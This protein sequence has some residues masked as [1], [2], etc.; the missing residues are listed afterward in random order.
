MSYLPKWQWL[1]KWTHQ[2]I[3]KDFD[4]TI[5]G[6][7][8]KGEPTTFTHPGERGCVEFEEAYVNG[9]PFELTLEEILK[10][11]DTMLSSIREE[12]SIEKRREWNI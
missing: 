4:V 9:K 10:V 12:I 7:F 11:E 3:D 6:S 8:W 5:Y 1:M 2:E